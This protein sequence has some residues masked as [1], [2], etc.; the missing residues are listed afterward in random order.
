MFKFLVKIFTLSQF[1]NED[2]EKFFH[3]I[4]RN[5]LIDEECP[6]PVDG[7][8]EKSDPPVVDTSNDKSDHSVADTK[9]DLPVVDITNYISD[10]NVSIFMIY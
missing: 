2:D 10:L 9:N 7:R 5:P 8:N 1:E 3:Q 4:T 6:N